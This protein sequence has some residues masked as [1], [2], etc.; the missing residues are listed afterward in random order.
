MRRVSF[1]T[2]LASASPGGEVGL[3]C[4]AGG[5]T[6]RGPRAGAASLARR[7][8]RAQRTTGGAGGWGGGSQQA[9]LPRP[10][11]SRAASRLL[12]RPRP[13]PTGR[14]RPHITL[15]ASFCLPKHSAYGKFL[16]NVAAHGV[17]SPGCCPC[18][19]VEDSW[20]SPQMS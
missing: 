15:C 1:S 13:W 5:V 17:Q 10:S 2:A 20:V 11:A 19:V 3:A 7:L 8:G 12:E 4:W 6:S 18:L 14:G 9:S 16:A